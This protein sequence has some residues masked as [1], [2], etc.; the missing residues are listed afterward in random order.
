MSYIDGYL[1]PVPSNKKEAYRAVAAQA[2]ALF[3]E[4]GATRIVESWGDA[5]P[6]G[7]VTDFKCAVQAQ[8]TE[9]VVFSWIEWPSKAARDVGNEKFMN[10]PRLKAFGDM[11]FGGK[12]MVLGG[13]ET[14]LDA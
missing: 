3:K 9:T 6:D 10:D 11:P 2:A 7:K 12:R 4:C 5:V 13:F 8:T 14:L 1:V